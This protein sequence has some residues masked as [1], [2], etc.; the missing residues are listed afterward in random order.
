MELGLVTAFLGGVLALLS[1]CGALLLPAFFASTVGA[2]P[3]LWLHGGVFYGGL[4]IVL[5]PLGIGAGALGA[6]F[7]AHREAVIVTASLLLIVFGLVQAL[8]FGFDPTRMLPGARGL[9]QRAGSRSGL[10]KTVMLGAVSGV[11]GFCTGPILG[12]VLTLAAAQGSMLTASILFGVYGAGM[13]VPLLLL[14][15]LWGRMGNRGRALMRGR[16]FRFLGRDL[17]TTSV[18]TGLLIAAVGVLFWT[19]NGLVGVPELVP[20]STQAWL[21]QRS[22][23][24]AGPVVDVLAILLAAGLALLIWAR[25]RRSRA[26][27]IAAREDDPDVEMAG[28]GENAGGGREG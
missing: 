5:V 19:T 2:G 21:Q 20:S 25:V 26:S 9:Q 10:V 7:T 12:A 23:L 13:V 4:L 18:V 24:L 15:T 28:R 16:T 6:L 17:H 1:P 11:A 22:G 27:V 14:A 3:R 8:G